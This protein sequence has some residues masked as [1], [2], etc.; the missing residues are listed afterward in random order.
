MDIPILILVGVLVG[1][2][3]GMFGVGGGIILIPALSEVLGPNQHL[4][5]STAMIVNLFVAVPAVYQHRM[6]KAIDFGAVVRIIPVAVVAVVFGVAVSELRV[7]TGAGEATLRGLFGAFLFSCAVYDVYRL[8]RQAGFAPPTAAVPSS[9]PLSWTALA[10]IA[11]PTGFISGLLGVGGGIVAV[12]LQRRFLGLPVRTAIANSAAIIVATSLVGAIVKNYAYLRDAE[13]QTRP[14]LLAGV[15]IPPAVLGSLL[16]SRLTHRV[17]ARLVKGGFV[18]L[19]LA[20]SIRL[21]QGA[22][23]DRASS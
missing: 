15:L 12:P 16:G 10:V 1:I 7:F 14:V 9:K 18:L 19:L 4:Y 11:I 3:G 5:Q 6:A 21:I 20:A 23:A 17:S 22:L 2:V 8:L 13:G